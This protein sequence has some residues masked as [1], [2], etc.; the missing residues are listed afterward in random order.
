MLNIA[1]SARTG[2]I[3][4]AYCT[5]RVGAYKVCHKMMIIILSVRTQYQYRYIQ[6]LSPT[7]TVPVLVQVQ[8]WYRYRTVFWNLR[9]RYNCSV[10]DVCI[11]TS[12]RVVASPSSQAATA[13]YRY[14][15]RSLSSYW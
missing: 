2:T 6:E 3:Q 1:T 9:Y 10:A 4:I 8:Y 13:E 7:G 15:E 14:F 5:V 12:V 11:G